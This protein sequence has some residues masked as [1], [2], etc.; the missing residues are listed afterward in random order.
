[1]GQ[2]EGILQ[3]GTNTVLFAVFVALTR[4]GTHSLNGAGVGLALIAGA[5]WGAYILL[6]GRV[7]RAFERGTGIAL[8]MC[9]ASIALLPVGIA[10]A[11]ARATCTPFR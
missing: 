2:G 4:G 8:S 6:N 9:V 5:L 1:M 11:N 3:A 7:G 10:A